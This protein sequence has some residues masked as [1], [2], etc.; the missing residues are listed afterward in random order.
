M[1][2]NNF[3][4]I[5]IGIA[6]ASATLF[7]G[8]PPPPEEEEMM[9]RPEMDSA[10]QLRGD[11]F[12]TLEILYSELEEGVHYTIEPIPA[13]L[14]RIKYGGHDFYYHTFNVKDN[15]TITLN[16]CDDADKVFTR[17]APDFRF[18]TESTDVGDAK[19]FFIPDDQSRETFLI[20]H[21]SGLSTGHY[22]CYAGSGSFEADDYP[23]DFE[24]PP[25]FTVNQPEIEYSVWIGSVHQDD[26]ER[27]GLKFAITGTLYVSSAGARD[28]EK[29]RLSFKEGDDTETIDV[30]EEFEIFKPEPITVDIRGT[31]EEPLLGVVDTSYIAERGFLNIERKE[32]NSVLTEDYWN[33]T[34][35]CSGWSTVLPSAI[36]NWPGNEGDDYVDET[37]RFY[38]VPADGNS[39]DDTLVVHYQIAEENN[40][41]MTGWYCSSYDWIAQQNKSVQ[42]GPLIEFGQLPPGTFKIWVA[43]NH[44]E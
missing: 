41:G 26:E 43:G 27:D 36:V 33:D 7:C 5:L 23:D 9:L 25:V 13:D 29:M 15:D 35:T 32:D 1:K 31:N 40:K 18:N 42:G 11:G 38:F 3:Y 2:K 20:L 14:D 21:Q 24:A 22:N 12:P 39:E 4:L 16:G 19:V 10:N 8:P 30:N 44:G 17:Q 34:P 28:P 37:L 6:L